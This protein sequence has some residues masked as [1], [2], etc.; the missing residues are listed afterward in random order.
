MSDPHSD[1]LA[2]RDPSKSGIAKLISWSISNQLIVLTLA[3]LDALSRC[4]LSRRSASKA[5]GL[6]P[7]ASVYL[8]LIYTSTS[9]KFLLVRVVR[10]LIKPD[11]YH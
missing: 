9:I 8:F 1:D 6:H 5:A 3:A 10:I 4:F 2:G 7:G 11:I